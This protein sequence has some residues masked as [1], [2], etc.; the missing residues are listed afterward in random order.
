MCWNVVFGNLK[1]LIASG[2]DACGNGVGCDCLWSVRTPGSS[3]RLGFYEASGG[4]GSF[5]VRVCEFRSMAIDYRP[6]RFCS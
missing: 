2:Y 4:L 3:F 6:P 5:L 1:R